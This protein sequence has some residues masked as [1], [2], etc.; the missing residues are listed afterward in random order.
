MAA[1]AAAQ[2]NASTPAVGETYHVE[3]RVGLWN[4][5]PDLSISSESLGVVGSEIDLVTDLGVEQK[6]LPEFELILRAARKHKFRIQ[7]LPVKYEQSAVLNRD[8]VFNGQVYHVGLP[9]NSIFDWKTWRFGYEYDFVYTDK[10]FVGVIVEAKYTDLEV[11]LDSPVASE[12]TRAKGPIPSLGTIARVYPASNFS[13][14]FE[15]TGSTTKL[16]NSSDIVEGIDEDHGGKYIDWELYGTT[17]FTDH[18]G[19][20]FGYRSIYVDYRIDDDS[21]D[22]E[23]KGFYFTGVVRF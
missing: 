15:L 5:D 21:G 19:A 9:V 18:V 14:T 2:F 16:L 20:E 12:F 8:I 23:L 1:P 22:L 11:A 13:V 6:R 7:Y 10:G 17:N 3:L 4:A